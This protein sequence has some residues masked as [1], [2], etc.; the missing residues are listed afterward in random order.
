MPSAGQSPR[1]S[2]GTAS[3]AEHD[4]RCFPLISGTF[5]A[6]LRELRLR[7]AGKHFR[8]PPFFQIPPTLLLTF[9]V[10]RASEYMGEVVFE[11]PK[12]TLYEC[13]T[14]S[15]GIADGRESAARLR[16]CKVPGG[17]YSRAF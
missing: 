16:N 14:V 12:R 3:M 9:S 13:R 1:G 10:F 2:S 17:T 8:G 5:P 15:T 4:I 6:T 11:F 7:I